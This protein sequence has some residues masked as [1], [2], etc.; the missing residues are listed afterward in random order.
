MQYLSA[1]T[2][3]QQKEKKYVLNL[4]IMIFFGRNDF[5]SLICKFIK[6]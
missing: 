3:V 6:N 2:I 1:K 4:A 5:K